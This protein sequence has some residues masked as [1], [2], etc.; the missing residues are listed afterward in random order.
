MVQ[1]EGL[2]GKDQLEGPAGEVDLVVHLGTLLAA[3]TDRVH[4]SVFV[5]DNKIVI[6]CLCKL[7]AERL[8]HSAA[9]R[10]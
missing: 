4:V 1:P 3:G 6:E 5:I 10:W 9:S 2:F 8:T 7:V